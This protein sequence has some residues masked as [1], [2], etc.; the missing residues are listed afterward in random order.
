MPQ[1]PISITISNS[2]D[3]WTPPS[4]W[5]SNAA[6]LGVIIMSGRAELPIPAA[7][8]HL[9]AC[10]AAFI[11]IRQAISIRFETAT[12]VV[13]P[14]D[15]SDRSGL[16]LDC[17]HQVDETAATV[18]HNVFFENTRPDVHQAAALS[19]VC[20][21]LRDQKADLRTDQKSVQLVA[22]VIAY[23]QAH[24]DDPITLDVLEQEFECKKALLARS[25]QAEQQETPMRVLARLRLEHA[26]HLLQSTD[27]TIS[28]IAH[29]TGYSDLAGFSHFFKQH[30]G[31]SPSEFRSNC[32]WLV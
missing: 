8:I 9:T 19:F 15:T 17:I 32:L 4:E 22:R 13:W 6:I 12:A 20:H 18:I 27:L 21:Q 31:Q 29:A 5:Q 1:R 23:M 14:V 7:P 10:T 16:A 24:L 28:Q 11:P 2:T 3:I 30:S 25:F 26:R